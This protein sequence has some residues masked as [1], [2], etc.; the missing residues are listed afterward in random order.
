MNN[1]FKIMSV[2][3][4]NLDIDFDANMF[5]MESLDSSRNGSSIFTSVFIG[6]N[7]VGKSHLLK[8]ISYM[9]M[10]IYN[11]K[12]FSETEEINYNLSD[13]VQRLHHL[14]K[15]VIEPIDNYSIQYKVDNIEF[16]VSKHKG[17][18]SI[19]KDHFQL[20]PE[21]YDQIQIPNNILCCAF[22]INDKFKFKV[23]SESDFYKYLGIKSQS[24]FTNSKTVEKKICDNIIKCLFTEENKLHLDMFKE[25]FKFLGL[26]TKITIDY[27]IKR[28]RDIFNDH[29]NVDNIA[30]EINRSVFKNGKRKTFASNLFSDIITDSSILESLVRQ[31]KNFNSL[32]YNNSFRDR[33]V[34]TIKTEI[35]LETGD[36]YAIT[37]YNEIIDMKSKI[38]KNALDL[39]NKLDIIGSPILGIKKKEYYSISN[40]SSGEVHILFLLSNIISNINKTSL[41]LIDEP[42][43]SLHPSWQI[44]IIN[45]LRSILLKAHKSC[46]I[47]IATHSHFI[48]SN[49][50]PKESTLHIIKNDLLNSDLLC[51]NIDYDIYGWSAENILYKVFG[52]P[53]NRNYYLAEYIDNLLEEISL[54]N[55]NKVLENKDKLISL[56]RNLSD[57]DPFKEVIEKIL[58][59]PSNKEVLE[60]INKLQSNKEG[61]TIG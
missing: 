43:I 32:L 29:I 38:D 49:L 52:V 11:I 25:C 20:P 15:I 31:I 2:K 39:L 17:K 45:L 37:P 1:N 50:E 59:L 7:G 53:S 41:I 51:E 42:E 18:I 40:G 48:V 46:H 56:S 21:Q 3:I 33:N 16:L 61:D 5:N 34:S 8:Y 12:Y 30:E 60:K 23:N 55:Y 13:R 14:T 28:R 58:E 35:N 36:F 9:F 57:I 4:N 24:G 22:Q 47:I 54:G 10:D 26:D 27:K 19:F 44:R 6:E